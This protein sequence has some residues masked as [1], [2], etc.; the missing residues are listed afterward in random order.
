MP[1]GRAND[2]ESVDT[3]AVSSGSVRRQ[4][5]LVEFDRGEGGQAGPGRARPNGMLQRREGVLS[6]EEA[7]DR[8][9]LRRRMQV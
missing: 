1:G 2:E 7:V 8:S 3:K 4:L 9:R 5:T 6:P